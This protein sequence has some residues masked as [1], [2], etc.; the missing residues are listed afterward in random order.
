MFLLKSL[1]VPKPL[2]L[3]HEHV[4][5]MRKKT[6]NLRRWWYFVSSAS[7]AVTEGAESE[8][9]KDDLL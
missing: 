5:L 8:V 6:E 7:E 2:D 1:E 3:P 9:P 4:H